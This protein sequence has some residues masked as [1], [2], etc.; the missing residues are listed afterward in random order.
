MDQIV[1]VLTLIKKIRRKEF[2]LWFNFIKKLVLTS[3]SLFL[4]VTLIY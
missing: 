2:F 4:F 1:K 3:L